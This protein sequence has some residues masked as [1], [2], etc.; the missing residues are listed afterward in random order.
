MFYVKRLKDEAT[1]PQ[2]AHA[3]DAGFDVFNTMDDFLLY[4]RDKVKIPL[5][6]AIEVPWGHVAL[7]QE[8]S[9]MAANQGIIT[10]GNVIDCGYRGEAHA[11]LFNL[12]DATVKIKKGQKVAQM[13]IVPCY[14]DTEYEVRDELSST[15]RGD[16]GFGST[17]LEAKS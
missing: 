10:I 15:G 8:K 11:I 7:I 13:L 1:M 9:G 4:P 16:G 2:K 12:T 14:C 5:G 17:G 6:F 3:G